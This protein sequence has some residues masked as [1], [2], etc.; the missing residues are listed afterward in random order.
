MTKKTRMTWLTS[1]WQAISTP[2]GT[3]MNIVNL[4]MKE[5][6]ILRVSVETMGD[7]RHTF[8]CF[9]TGVTMG[10][11]LSRMIYIMPEKMSPTSKTSKLT[12]LTIEG[13]P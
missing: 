4:L 9:I 11:T 6:V 12:V 8:L 1:R 10:Y 13:F 3:V 7:C 2:V 5:T